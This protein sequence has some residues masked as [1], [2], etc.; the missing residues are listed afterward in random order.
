MLRVRSALGHLARSNPAL[1]RVGASWFLTNLAEWAYVTALSIHGYR[2][3][4]AIAVGLIG[5]RFVPGAVSGS[6]LV[7]VLMRR[8]PM[9]TLRF[10]SLG[11][12][13]AATLAAIAVAADAPLAVLVAI[14]WIDAVIAAPYRPLMASTL[15]ALSTT[16]RELSAVAGS[17]PASKALAQALGALTGGLGLALVAPQTIALIAAVLFLV[18]AV[19]IA[20]IRRKARLVPAPSALDG[21]GGRRLGA[22]VAGFEAIRDRAGILLMLGGLRS[23]TRGLWTSLAVVVSIELLHLGSTGVGVLMGSA[24]VGAAIAVWLSLVFAGRP[25]LAGPS[26]L[27]FAI[28]GVA[29]VLVGVTASPAPAIALMAIWGVALALADSISNSLVHRVVHARL[30]APSIAAVESSKLLLEGVGALAAPA[31][32]AVVGVRTAVILAGVPL[33][34]AVAGSRSRLRA[35][36][37]RAE[38]RARP[39][40]ALRRTPT[41]DGLTM[42]GLETLSARLEEAN[43]QAD[44]AIVRQGEVGDR[45][46]LIDSGQVKVTV[47]GFWVGD[48]GAGGSFGEKALL[49]AAPRSATVTALEPT[50]LWYL[51]AADFIAAATGEEAPTASRFES[52]AARSVEDLLRSVPMFGAIDRHRLAAEGEVVT[53]RA[54]SQIVT[55]GAAADLFYAL[56]DGEAEVRIDGHPRGKLV[57]GDWFGEIALLHDVLRT[58][59]VVATSDVVLWQ[60]QRREFLAVLGRESQGETVGGQPVAELLV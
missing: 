12:T 24:G 35:I 29:I 53:L 49:K 25:R 6:T 27:C 42:L 59:D 56:L 3:A 10:L 17:I 5:A 34:L 23:L 30:L 57:G 50:R 4:G 32:L 28:C 16:P 45:F 38:A 36:D 22:I 21:S 14:V 51:D 54:G 44:E 41:F 7:G 15:P 46:Y 58:A 39:L 20:P 2:T 8:P 43:A 40:R 18:T 47:D 31:L 52:T 26:A 48:I 9:P 55:Q 37:Q 11:R 13:T 60:L 19:L 1:R 33:V